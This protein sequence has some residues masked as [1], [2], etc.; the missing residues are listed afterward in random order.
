MGSHISVDVPPTDLSVVAELGRSGDSRASSSSH[1]GDGDGGGMLPLSLED[2]AS[3]NLKVWRF[4]GGR[5][6]GT[7]VCVSPVDLTQFQGFRSDECY[8]VMHLYAVTPSILAS[9]FGQHGSLMG[10]SRSDEVANLSQ[11]VSVHFRDASQPPATARPGDTPFTPRKVPATAAAA[12]AAASSSFN[13]GGLGVAGEESQQ[14]YSHHQPQQQGEQQR[15]SLTDLLRSSVDNLSPRGLRSSFCGWTTDPAFMQQ[16]RD[17]YMNGVGGGYGSHSNRSS[18][19]PD[20]NTIP[21]HSS[22]RD[23]FGAAAG[24]RLS[25]KQSQLLRSASSNGSFE[26]GAEGSGSHRGSNVYRQL[27]ALDGGARGGAGSGAPPPGE[28]K[29]VHDLYVWNGRTALPLTK[30][31]CLTRGFELERLFLQNPR[32]LAETLISSPSSS[33][34]PPQKSSVSPLSALFDDDVELHRPSPQWEKPCSTVNTF[35]QNHHLFR[36]I[37]VVASGSLD[38]NGVSISA[39]EPASSTMPAPRP[40]SGAAKCGASSSGYSVPSLSLSSGAGDIPEVESLSARSRD[41]DRSENSSTDAPL[42]SRRGSSSGWY[43]SGPGSARKRGPLPGVLDDSE[44]PRKRHEALGSVALPLGIVPKLHNL[45]GLERSESDPSPTPRSPATSNIPFLEQISGRSSENSPRSNRELSYRSSGS[46]EDSKTPRITSSDS[47]SSRVGQLCG[48]RT[49]YMTEDEASRHAKVANAVKICTAID[50]DYLYLGSDLVAR[51]LPQLQSNGITHVVNTAGTICNNYFD[52]ELKY[53]RLNL[54]DMASQDIFS[55]FLEVIDFIE[56][57]RSEKGKVF[58]H[59]Q[60]GVSRSASFVIAY[61]MWR[62]HLDYDTAFNRVREARTVCS[63][64]PGFIFQLLNWQGLLFE[65]DAQFHIHRCGV[66]SEEYRHDIVAKQ[67]EESDPRNIVFDERTSW[68]VWGFQCPAVF[69]WIGQRSHPLYTAK[70]QDFASLLIKYLRLEAQIIVIEESNPQHEH[71]NLMVQLLDFSSQDD[72]HRGVVSEYDAEY[73]LDPL[74][75]PASPEEPGPFQK[76]EKMLR[77]EQQSTLIPVGKPQM[78]QFAPGNADAE[79]PWEYVSMFDMDDLESDGIFLVTNDVVC[80]QPSKA[81][82]RT[83]DQ[84]HAFLWFGQDSHPPC[85]E[86]DLL[87]QVRVF[88]SSC[89]PELAQSSIIVACTEEDEPDEF[90]DCFVNG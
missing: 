37:I 61:L 43:G 71:L 20:H 32:Q 45:S 31:T 18:P 54:Y 47:D 34:S 40:N 72:I 10:V 81:E 19:S 60:Q 46:S 16:E 59:C 69:V 13:L 35:I 51:N 73:E 39:K 58:V 11:V 7:E 14:Q 22:S 86:E 50:S 67:L 55:Y 75:R 70:A 44:S 63:P 15:L 62:D 66:F 41:T 84:I 27:C 9:V 57:A 89:V 88:L 80:P 28:V 68:V 33:A 36:R 25:G 6:D 1:K 85:S 42:S 76:D 82:T 78:F 52:G 12:V 21:R 83:V 77:E 53:K 17:Y 8:I 87:D 49:D 30:A 26:S 29:Y 3:S 79:V 48:P 4:Y 23:Q 5:G 38:G 24:H 2:V 56:N 74:S 90:F 64:N 65:P